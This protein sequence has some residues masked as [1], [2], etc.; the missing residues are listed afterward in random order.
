MKTPIDPDR[1]GLLKAVV[2]AGWPGIEVWYD[3]GFWFSWPDGRG[4]R[5]AKRWVA[6][7]RGSDFPKWSHE[8]PAGGTWC[9]VVTQL[10]RWCRGRPVIPLR[11]WRYW[12]GPAVGVKP[13]VLRLV[14]AAGWPEVVPCIACGRPIGPDER[15]DEYGRGGVDG[16][17]CVP[18]CAA[19]RRV[20]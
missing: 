19:L 11:C 4:G 18:M 1:L 16:P 5:T 12:C 2:A 14:A 20:A 3:R 10:M 13:E 9:R 17:G 15:F 8:K 6:S 7:Y